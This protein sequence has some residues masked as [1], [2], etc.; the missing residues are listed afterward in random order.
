MSKITF[1]TPSANDMYENLMSIEKLQKKICQLNQTQY[2]S[3]FKIIS[4]ISNIC[5]K[6]I[7]CLT[8][9]KRVKKNVIIDFVHLTEIVKYLNSIND[10]L[11]EKYHID[12]KKMRMPH[13]NI[14]TPKN[15]QKLNNVYQKIISLM[16]KLLKLIDYKLCEY[17]DVI[18]IV[19]NH[20]V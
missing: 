11:N 19:S 3:I 10:E 7:S 6:N 18:S 16:K 13:E 9:F 1:N 5:G 20:N 15:K 2:N 12:C 4:K 17:D 14:D 8:G